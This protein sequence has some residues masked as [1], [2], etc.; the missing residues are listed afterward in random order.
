[1][2][3][4][5]VSSPIDAPF[6]V[7]TEFVFN[8]HSHLLRL[9]VFLVCFLGSKIPNLSFGG[10]GPMFPGHLNGSYVFQKKYME[11]TKVGF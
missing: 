6:F 1:M 2:G 9:I 8:H 4:N 3:V 11:N 7:G 10:P 5:G